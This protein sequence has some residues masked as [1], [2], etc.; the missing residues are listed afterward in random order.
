M[1]LTIAIPAPLELLSEIRAEGHHL[2]FVARTRKEIEA[3]LSGEDDRFIIVLGPCSLH[4]VESSLEYAERVRALADKVSDRFLLVM[5]AYFEK[6]RTSKGWKGLLYDPHLDGSYDVAYGLQLTRRILIK[7]AELQVPAGSEFLEIHTAPYFTDLIS[8]GCIGAR[9]VCSQPHRQ[10]AA[11]LPLPIGF[12]NTT[13]GSIACAVNGMVA[14]S[15]PHIFL[16]LNE[17]GTLERKEASGNPYSHLVLRGS[18]LRPN[19]DSA[20]VQEALSLTMRAGVSKRIFIDCAHGNSGKR[21]ERQKTVFEAIFE[22]NNPYIVGTMLESH[23]HA[24]HQP[25]S[26]QARYGI[27]VTD[28]CLNW[29]STH[30]M[31]LRAYC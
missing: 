14:A 20:S 12:K 30:E 1:T 9:T 6:P 24:G 10:L 17:S 5:R 2:D 28:P 15:C 19:Y 7:L 26:P 25:L 13:E 4:D 27:S 16:S 29:D 11:S 3:I 21:A 31:I 18:S 8:W 22:Q 23:L